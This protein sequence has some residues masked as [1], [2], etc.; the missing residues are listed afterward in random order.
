MIHTKIHIFKILCVKEDSSETMLAEFHHFLEVTFKELSMFISIRKTTIEEHDP[1]TTHKASL[2]ISCNQLLAETQLFREA[3]WS[4]GY[5]EENMKVS[6]YYTNYEHY[7][8]LYRVKQFVS[9]F[10]KVSDFT[11]RLFHIFINVK[12]K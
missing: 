5:S 8:L 7:L 11:F 6:L 1:N 3:L 12:Y 10:Q 2:T 9:I 4:L